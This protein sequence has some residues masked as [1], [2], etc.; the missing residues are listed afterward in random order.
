MIWSRRNAIAQA[1]G[2]V[3]YL[4]GQRGFAK[5][6]QPSTALDFAMP[7]H[8]CDC[9]THIFGDV[10]NF[11]LFA[12]RSYT[13]STAL[14]REMSAL[15]RSLRVERVVIV[16]PSIYGTDN[17]STVYG[18]KARRGTSKGIAVIDE[19]TTEAELDAMAA[20]GFCGIRLN[21]ATGA[22]VD[23]AAA[24]RRLEAAID[25]VK[26]RGWHIQI[27]ASLALITS[28]KDLILASPV[29]I[30]IDHV[31]GAK[32]S[33]GVTQAGFDVLLEAVRSGKAYVKITH[34]YIPSGKP[35]D[36]A[37]AAPLAK[38]LIEANADRILW[39]TDWPH[40]DA[41]AHPGRKPTDVS[42]LLAIDDGLLLNRFARW[43]GSAALL[44]KILAENPQRLYRF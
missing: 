20:A 4:G 36:Y 22:S 24:R 15:H 14:P 16:T 26:G 3:T 5:A 30:V 6:S 31:A 2:A 13:P 8:A 28:V 35:P 42:P 29:P 40:P 18:L 11:P 21:L 12:G 19:R 27:Y 41:D 33:L 32:P 9:H 10:K 44:Q 39:G 38:A 7:E 1:L 37:D 43:V 23:T 34:R 17:S 25:R